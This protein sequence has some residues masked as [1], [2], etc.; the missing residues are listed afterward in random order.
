MHV[1]AYRIF[2]AFYLSLKLEIKNPWRY[3]E[4]KISHALSSTL[5]SL[6]R[7]CL[8]Y[9]REIHLRDVPKLIAYLTTL[10]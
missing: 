7:P 5:D 9:Q 3:S 8:I 10:G 1:C 4:P 6:D 2:I